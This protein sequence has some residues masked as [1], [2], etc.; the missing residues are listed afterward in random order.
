VELEALN[1]DKWKAALRERITAGEPVPGFTS[2]PAPTTGHEAI[3]KSLV[4]FPS[5]ESFIIDASVIMREIAP[6]AKPTLELYTALAC[7]LAGLSYGIESM[8]PILSRL[9]AWAAAWGNSLG[10]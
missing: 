8:I 7:E 5:A 3:M 4:Q 1:H 9:P 6:T 2:V 10:K